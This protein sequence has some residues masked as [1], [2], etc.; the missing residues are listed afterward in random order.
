M[1]G[2]AFL[3][4]CRD[5]AR[6]IINFSENSDVEKYLKGES[7]VIQA[8]DGWALVC[9]EGYPLGWAKVLDG[10]MKNKYLK[11]WIMR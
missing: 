10:R 9:V 2:K 5:D 4:D 3:R 7:F 11:S 8:A 6:N 1:T